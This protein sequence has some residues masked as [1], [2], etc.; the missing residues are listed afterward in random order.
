[1]VEIQNLSVR[2]NRQRPHPVAAVHGGHEHDGHQD[3]EAGDEEADH[4]AGAAGGEGRGTR[5]WHEVKK[6]MTR[7]IVFCTPGTT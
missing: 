2:K 6:H 4:Q 3:N 1:M 7:P 5:S